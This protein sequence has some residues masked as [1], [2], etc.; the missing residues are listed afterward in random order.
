MMLYMQANLLHE[1]NAPSTSEMGG[2]D[3]D[4]I[5]GAYEKINIDFFYDVQVEHA[6]VIL[7]HFVHDMSSEELIL[8]Q[9]AYRLLLLFVEFCGR[10]LDRSTKLVSA[11]N[12]ERL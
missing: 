7:S 10:I 11:C 1:L 4:A 3:Y 9:S 12:K 6:L 8:R 2:L 5:L